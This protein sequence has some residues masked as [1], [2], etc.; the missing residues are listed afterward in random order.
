MHDADLVT[1]LASGV[2]GLRPPAPALSVARESGR[3]VFTVYEGGSHVGYALEGQKTRG[4]P[5]PEAS[6]DRPAAGVVPPGG[7]RAPEW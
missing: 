2:S 5:A 3:I 6:V 7:E 4:K 1:R